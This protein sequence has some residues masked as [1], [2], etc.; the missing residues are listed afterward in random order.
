MTIAYNPWAHPMQNPFKPED[1]NGQNRS[2]N[3]PFW[4]PFLG[5]QGGPTNPVPSNGYPSSSSNPDYP[6][7]ANNYLMPTS[8]AA[9]A[10]PLPQVEEKDPYAYLTELQRQ[11]GGLS[12]DPNSMA[13]QAA[14]A[15]NPAIAAIKKEKGLAT[16]R[17]GENRKMSKADYQALAQQYVADSAAE[18]KAAA[19]EQVKMNKA[20]TQGVAE[21]S[22][23]YNKIQADNQA[24]LAGLGLGASTQALAKQAIETQAAN[25]IDVVKSQESTQGEY[26]VNEANA[27]ANYYQAGVGTAKQAGNEQDAALAR[28]LESQLMAL[29]KEQS[30]V[31][32]QAAQAANQA[33]QWALGYGLQKIGTGVSLNEA[34]NQRQQQIFDQQRAQAAATTPDI[35]KLKGP[36]AA[37]SYLQNGIGDANAT[38]AFINALESDPAIK[39]GQYM[40]QDGSN[41]LQKV[42]PVMAM[43]IV[44]NAAIKA[45]IDPDVAMNYWEIYNK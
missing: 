40:A 9:Q 11:L 38:V 5:V 33:R 45:G 27:M 3:Q 26:A 24:E 34:V 1:V 2:P 15:Y 6:S 17:S 8:P 35:S 13:A 42:T 32:T 21:T 12:A 16:K 44:R 22:D 28:A 18:K 31:Q 19:A 23:T 30:G 25:A 4:N 14:G 39:T 20:M 43:A 7:S 10:I 29:T 36:S 41:K 37:R